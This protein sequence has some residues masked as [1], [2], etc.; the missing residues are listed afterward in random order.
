MDNYKTNETAEQSL[1]DKFLY[2]MKVNGYY[3]FENVI[4]EEMLK[5]LR[6]AI[7]NAF[8]TDEQALASGLYKTNANVSDVSRLMLGRDKA[9]EDLI[10][11]SPIQHY[12]DLVL[13][14]T[15]VINNYSAVRLMP[16]KKNVVGNIHKDSPRHSQQFKLAIQILYFVD[17][18]TEETGGTWILPGSHNAEEQPSSEVFFANGK[19]ITGKAGSAMVF[20]SSLWHAG[21]FNVSKNPRRGIAIV[22]T[23]SFIKQQI[24]IVRALPKEMVE[25]FSDNM[26]RLIGYNVRVPSSLEEFY[27]P[28]EERMYKAGQG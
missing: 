28:N 26:K 25:K 19:Q 8:E 1:D 11:S 17:D 21:G 7:D 14:K 18:F 2:N 13:S 9:F 22:Y 6:V 20:D 24:D 15:C 4:N 5:N 16:N 10:E 3:I 12:V 23:R 27:L